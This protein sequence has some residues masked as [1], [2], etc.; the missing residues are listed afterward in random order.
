MSQRPL[1]LPKTRTSR[2]FTHRSR[3]PTVMPEPA[4]A[5]D[6][7]WVQ[8]DALWQTHEQLRQAVPY[9]WNPLTWEEFQHKLCG[10]SNC[11]RRSGV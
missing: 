9:R 7:R 5:V 11:C 1:L 4:S 10:W 3:E 6:P 8:V 2:S